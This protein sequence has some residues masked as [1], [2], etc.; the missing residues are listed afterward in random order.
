MVM[1]KSR[2]SLFRPPVARIFALP[3]RRSERFTPVMPALSP[4]STVPVK[5]R[6]LTEASMSM[7]KSRRF[8]LM[9]FAEMV[10]KPE[11]KVLSLKLK[12]SMGMLGIGFS[13]S[14]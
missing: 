4:M 2:V 8:A 6:P 5:G 12:R 11:V 10:P 9:L 13:S 7:S 1:W 3:S 14:A